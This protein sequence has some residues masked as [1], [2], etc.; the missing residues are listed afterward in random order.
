MKYTN[1]K[2]K[3]SPHFQ[4]EKDQGLLSPMS[5]VRKKLNYLDNIMSKECYY[6]LPDPP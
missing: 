3:N 6:A 4:E 2:K 5:Y 1:Y